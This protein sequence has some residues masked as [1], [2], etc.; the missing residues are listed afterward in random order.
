MSNILCHIAGI[1][2][3]LKHTFIDKILE[4]YN[5]I[6]FIDLDQLSLNIKNNNIML[7]L[8]YK[9]EKCP[10]A[11]HNN[12]ENGSQKSITIQHKMQKYWKLAM[13]Q[14]LNMLI[15]KN[16]SKKIVLL[17]SCSYN[18]IYAKCFDVFT[19]CKYFLSIDLK[20]NAQK[21][22]THNLDNYRKAI[23]DGEFPLK[24]LDLAYLMEARKEAIDTYQENG[25]EMRTSTQMVNMIVT[26]MDQFE[27]ISNI[28][29]IY[30]CST[31]KYDNIIP[32]NVSYN[33][34]K[35]VIGYT[36]MWLA[37]LTVVP[38]GGKINKGFINGKPFIRELAKNAMNMFNVNCYIYTVKKDTFRFD[39]KGKQFKLL[40]DDNVV[41]IKRT[42]IANVYKKLLMNKPKIEVIGA[43]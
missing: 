37:L 9:L 15:N 42:Y 11:G 33:D 31:E 23:I 2:Q 13:Q 22:I 3:D 8:K 26:Q 24:Y 36:E 1:N 25:Y 39:P 28:G 38:N 10:K 6:I 34:N 29:T 18:H 41:V 40:S 32:G 19:P 17:G 43:K 30:V 20:K 27:S 4:N 14:K 12:L 16:K 35:P 5:R 21:I 7:E